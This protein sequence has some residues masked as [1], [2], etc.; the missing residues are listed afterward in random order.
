MIV[1]RFFVSSVASAALAVTVPVLAQK[2]P[3][4]P[5]NATGQ[6]QDSTFT[7][8]KTERGAC[9]RHGGVKT[10]WGAAGAVGTGAT[11]PQCGDR[12]FKPWKSALAGKVFCY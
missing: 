3:T 10:W 6:C 9:S 4:A 7:T 5:A 8:A 1:R 11:R 2:P 12:G